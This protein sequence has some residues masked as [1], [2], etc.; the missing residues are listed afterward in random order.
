MI[1]MAPPAPPNHPG[2]HEVQAFDP[3]L[4]KYP[5]R[6][7]CLGGGGT[8]NALIQKAGQEGRTSESLKKEFEKTAM[9]L[10]RQGIVGYGEFACEHL[11]LSK[12]HNHQSAPPDHPLFLLLSDIAAKN[13]LP[14]D[15]HMDAIVQDMP[16]PGGF[17]SPP[18]PK[19]LSAN[20]ANMERLL[21][22]NRKTKVIWS[23]LGWE[24]TGTRTPEFVAGLLKRH[25][26]LYFSFKICPKDSRPETMPIKIGTGLKSDWLDLIR[27]FPDRFM[28]GSDQFYPAPSFRQ[29]GPPSVEPTI[30]FLNLLP[31]DLRIKV[32]SQNASRIFNLH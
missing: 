12:T 5:N 2:S 7:A 27:A 26:N 3:V 16:L 11:C 14:I 15:I 28:I 32:G 6:F 25:E 24:N 31:P 30:R 1:L 9:D 4:K 20:V 10:V 23:H 22:H 29:V 21:A 8:L 17:L 19:T 13:N 18:N